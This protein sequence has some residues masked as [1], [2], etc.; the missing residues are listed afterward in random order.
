MID[1]KAKEI[2]LVA[3]SEI[4]LNPKNRNKHNKQQRG[5]VFSET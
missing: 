4:K 5:K 1:I 3:L 2:K